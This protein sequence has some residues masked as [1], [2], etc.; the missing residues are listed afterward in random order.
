M[1]SMGEPSRLLVARH[2]ETEDN[3]A[4]RWQGWRDSALTE[5]GIAQAQALGR[6]LRDEP[7]AAVYASDLGRAL[8]TARVATDGLDLEVVPCAGL[9]ER[10]VGLFSGLTGEQVRAAF[11]ETVLRRDDVLAWAPP[12]GESFTEVLARVIA[13][14]EAIARRWAG[15]T[16][17][18]VTHGGVLRLLAARSLGDDWARVYDHHPSNCGLSEFSLDGRGSLRLVR[19]DE[20]DYLDTELIG[21][22]RE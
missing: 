12:G 13:A 14:L 17:F 10:N 9:R 2:G 22:L 16:V 7:I 19:F 20:H 11:P 21:P 4:E 3:A 1:E 5:R 18:V 15:R 8:H 6:R